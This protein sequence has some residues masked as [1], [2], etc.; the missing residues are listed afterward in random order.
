MTCTRGVL[1]EGAKALQMVK[2]Q[3]L[4]PGR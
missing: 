1:P 3:V 2:S 4:I